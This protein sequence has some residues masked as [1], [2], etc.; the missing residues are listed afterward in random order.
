MSGNYPEGVTDAD[1]C[2]DTPSV[3]DDEDDEWDCAYPDKCLM[4]S[5]YHLRGEC[6]TVEDMEAY[7]AEMEFGGME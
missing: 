1:Y 7:Y 5:I 2:F 6:H 3:G 4:P